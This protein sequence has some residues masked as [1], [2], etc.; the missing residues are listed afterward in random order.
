MVL[1][2]V[3]ICTVSK[4]FKPV[5]GGFCPPHSFSNPLFFDLA[6]TEIKKI[7]MNNR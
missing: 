7:K 3:V 1:I 2:W 6:V 4:V 5:H